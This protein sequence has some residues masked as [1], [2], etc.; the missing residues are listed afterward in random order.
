MEEPMESPPPEY[1][2]IV[3]A[4]SSVQAPHTLRSRIESERERTLIRRTVVKRMKLSGV[5]AGAAAVLGVGVALVAPSHGAPSSLDAAALATRGA[6]AAAPHV[7][8]SHTH[9]LAASIG[10]VPFPRWEERFPW[11][12]SGQ[13]TDELGGRSTLTVFY[14]DPNGVRLGYT[15]VDGKPLAWPDGGRTVTSHNVD[16]HLLRQGDRIIATWRAH[17]HTCVISAPNSVPGA[18]MVMLASSRDYIA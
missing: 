11:K 16:V 13:R 1:D 3:A 17:G 12:P 15:I 10:G 8:P 9:L 2:R 4:M 18:R 5:L 14:D 7:N 6:V